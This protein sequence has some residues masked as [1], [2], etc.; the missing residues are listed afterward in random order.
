[1]QD[2]YAADYGDFSK[3]GLLRRLSGSDLCVGLNWYLTDNES[4]NQDG[5]HIDYLSPPHR[6]FQSL[7]S[8]DPDLFRN[9]QKLITR[10]TRSVKALQTMDIWPQ[11]TRFYEKRLNYHELAFQTINIGKDRLNSYY[12]FSQDLKNQAK[13]MNNE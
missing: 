7:L 5:R 2:R 13:A 12:T 1:M 8:C 10:G 6:H 11:H 9:L 4:H 3:C